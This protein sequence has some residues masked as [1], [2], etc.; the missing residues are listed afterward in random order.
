[1][2]EDRRKTMTGK[3]SRVLS[4]AAAVLA[5]CVLAGC[6]GYAA[7]DTR[8]DSAPADSATAETAP[9]LNSSSIS[10]DSENGAYGLDVGTVFEPVETGA[11]GTG[12]AATEEGQAP[13]AIPDGQGA[14]KDQRK[15]IRTVNMEVETQEYDRFLATLEEAVRDAGGYIENMESYNGSSY[16]GSSRSRYAG[17]TLR[18]PQGRLDSFLELVSDAGNV[19]RRTEGVEDVTLS[20]VDL[21]SHRNALRMEQERLLELLEQAESLDDILVIEERL[22][23]VRYQLES[24]ESRLRTMDDQVDYSTV[25]LDVSEVR[26]LTPV[27]ERTVWDRI[28]EGFGRSLG[29]IGNGAVEIFIWFVAHIPYILLL[30]AAIALFLLFVKVHWNRSMKKAARKRGQEAEERKEETEDGKTS[31]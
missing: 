22:T 4:G 20:Y 2:R 7:G 25:Y 18:I 11:L 12:E 15:L 24:M 14:Q 9:D 5:A 29:D 26:Q 1:M 3:G 13:G 21:E 27:E 6:G 8:A 19:V 30:A 28:E 17:M 10:Y 16:S 31:I 23:D